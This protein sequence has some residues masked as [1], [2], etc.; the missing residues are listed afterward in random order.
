MEQVLTRNY[1]ADKN[2]ERFFFTGMAL[3]VALLIFVGFAPSYYLKPLFGVE[4]ASGRMT[5]L[6]HIHGLIFTLWIVFLVAQTVLVARKRTDLHRRLGVGGMAL[7]LLMLAIGFYLQLVN[8]KQGIT[9]AGVPPLAFFGVAVADLVAFSALLGAGFYFRRR[10]DM[11]KRLM[12][13]ATI[14]LLT[15]ATARFALLALKSIPVPGLFIGWFMLDVLI[16]VCAV[17]DYRTLG[18]VH[19]ATLIGGAFI[20]LSEPLRL[21]VANTALWQQFAAWMA[22]LI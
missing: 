14:S 3:V 5:V 1:A 6:H 7:A 21:V 20:V 18:R 2:T 19:R 9:V 10:P 17:F 15:P 12:L 22:R 13:L 11:H 8:L 16:V 4:P